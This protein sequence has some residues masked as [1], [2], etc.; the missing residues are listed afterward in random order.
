MISR[1]KTALLLSVAAL[2]LSGCLA[3]LRDE[4]ARQGAEM[5]ISPFDLPPT[6]W[7]ST[8]I[9]RW[10]YINGKGE[11]VIPPRF[12]DAGEF[13]ANGL[14][15]VKVGE[16]YG[17][18]NKKG[19]EVIPPRFDET[20]GF[21]ANGLAPVKVGRKWGFINEKGEEVIPPRFDD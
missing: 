21:S 16:K 10:G 4:S 20:Y 6:K 11:I 18:I 8:N 9:S 15:R 1:L 19:E 2:M 12:G 7:S 17:F 3:S 14:A 5:E 13:S